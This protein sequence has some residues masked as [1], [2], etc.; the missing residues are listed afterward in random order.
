MSRFQLAL[1]ITLMI[2]GFSF[3][4]LQAHED[5]APA[6]ADAP[7]IQEPADAEKTAG[8]EDED[9]AVAGK[10]A[11]EKAPEFVDEMEKI[12]WDETPEYI[13]GQITSFVMKCSKGTLTPD[14]VKVYRFTAPDHEDTPHYMADYSAFRDHPML[15]S[16]S[17]G[18]HPC[19]DSGCLLQVYTQTEPDNFAPSLRPYARSFTIEKEVKDN[20]ELAV[21]RVKQAEKT[22]S[23]FDKNSKKCD[24]S[25][26]WINNK[27]RYFGLVLKDDESEEKVKE[28]NDR[29]REQLE[30]ATKEGPKKEDDLD[31]AEIIEPKE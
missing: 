14:K 18:V 15:A 8:T 2:S 7:A 26:T 1:A 28:R 9:G 30:Q 23:T 21:V 4:P 13:R 19:R 22:C 5:E 3:L 10:T 12:K 31:S 16:C 27:F 11:E 29:F 20:R 25:F 24:I 6:G 17:Y